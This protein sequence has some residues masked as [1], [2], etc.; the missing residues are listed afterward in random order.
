[1]AVASQPVAARLVRRASGPSGCPS[2]P[3]KKN[4]GVKP[5]L[6]EARSC[7]ERLLH[8]RHGGG[9][10]GRLGLRRGALRGAVLL[11]D[12]LGR[13]LHLLL[14]GRS[15]GLGRR[16][17]LLGRVARDRVGRG[18]GL[19]LRRGLRLV[20]ESNPERQDGDSNESGKG[21]LHF[22]LQSPVSVA[23]SGFTDETLSATPLPRALQMPCQNDKEYFLE[24]F[25]GSELRVALR[26]G[27]AA[28]HL[29][30]HS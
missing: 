3:Q 8:G 28:M 15:L 4:P 2:E 27:E 11:R 1:M 5:G 18:L 19:G 22:V 30:V 14:A 13:L 16:R 26:C 7:V 23:G 9:G 21:L 24:W 29:S 20:G 10:G 12:L 17:G 25:R 6:F